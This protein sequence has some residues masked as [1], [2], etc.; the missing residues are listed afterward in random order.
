MHAAGVAA[1]LISKFGPMSPSKVSAR[2]TQTAD[3]QPCPATLPTGYA[4][5][6]G[7]DDEQVQVCQGARA[8]TPRTAR[9]R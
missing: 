1:L 7:V 8:R 9:A 6:L 4:A 3:P 5:I 2:L